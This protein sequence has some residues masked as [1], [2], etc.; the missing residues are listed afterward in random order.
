[1]LRP[2]GWSAP[3]QPHCTQGLR[4][5]A[6]L[7]VA[8]VCDPVL[9][10]GLDL[11]EPTGARQHIRTKIGQDDLRRIYRN[12]R[13]LPPNFQIRGMHT[14]IRDRNTGTPAQPSPALPLWHV[15]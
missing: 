7:C 5:R 11:N 3:R 1:M 6:A 8:L 14:I 10:R 4:G 9:C 13:V 15:L 12:L 2:I